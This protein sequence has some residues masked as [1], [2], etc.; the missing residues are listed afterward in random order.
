MTLRQLRIFI[1]FS[2]SL[3]MT[4]TAVEL[5]VT[6]PCV[7]RQLALLQ[8]EYRT[9]FFVQFNHGIKLTNQGT[10]F[11]AAVRPALR[12]LENIQK[13]FTERLA[14]LPQR[15][16]R[17]GG[18]ESCSASLLPKVSNIYRKIYSDVKI[19]LLTGNNKTIERKLADSEIELALITEPSDDPTIIVEPFRSEQVVAVA[20]PK[21]PL[22]KNGKV[23]LKDLSNYCF[24]KKLDGRISRQIEQAGITLNFVMECQSQD[25]LKAAVEA[26]LGIGFFPYDEVAQDLNKGSLKAVPISDLKDVEFRRFVAYRKGEILSPEAHSLLHLLHHW[27]YY[28]DKKRKNFDHIPTKRS[29]RAVTRIQRYIPSNY[30]TSGGS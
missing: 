26:G 3:N 16:L 5:G 4:K 6:Q 11:L 1:A 30:G 8:K 17:I 2:K 24:V 29:L 14:N 7:S 28:R 13:R 27:P 9:K 20:S 15:P 19:V 22:R 12:N 25:A 23:K 10:E 18:S 21:Y